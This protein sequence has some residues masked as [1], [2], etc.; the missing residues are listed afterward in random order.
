MLWSTTMM[1]TDWG[2]QLNDEESGGHSQSLLKFLS[3]GATISLNHVI[4]KCS[5]WYLESLPISQEPNGSNGGFEH[6]QKCSSNLWLP[7]CHQHS[8]K[9]IPSQIW[10][11]KEHPYP[12]RYTDQ[13][14]S[15]YHIYIQCKKRGHI[16]RPSKCV[17]SSA[18][19]ISLQLP[20]NICI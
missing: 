2:K 13:R 8:S 10:L 4:P 19:H 11:K 18:L 1:H 9:S 5:K 16:Q 3:P 17:F 20:P 12:K 6:G 15:I 14:K 7:A